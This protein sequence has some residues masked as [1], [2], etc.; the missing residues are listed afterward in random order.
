MSVLWLSITTHGQTHNH[1]AAYIH[2]DYNVLNY[3][4]LWTPRDFFSDF[5]YNTIYIYESMRL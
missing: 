4:F 5:G 3:Y 1:P 2:K